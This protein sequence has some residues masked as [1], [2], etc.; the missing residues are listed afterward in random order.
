MINLGVGLLIILSSCQKDKIN[1]IDVNS[2][3]NEK[4][5]IISDV[6]FS[7]EKPDANITFRFDE[8]IDDLNG[9]AQP[10]FYGSFFD[11]ETKIGVGQLE[12]MEEQFFL[13]S[14][15]TYSLTKNI[16]AAEID[17]TSTQCSLFSESEKF[18]SFNKYVYMP[19]KMNVKSNIGLGEAFYKDKDLTL[20]WT[21]DINIEKV[22]IGVCS[23]GLP[24]III[25]VENSGSTTISKDEFS[26]FL[27]G[28]KVY[29]HLGRG[30]QNCIEMSNGN[31]ICFNSFNNAKTSG[32]IVEKM[33]K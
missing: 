27:I 26:D 20:N 18:D 3:I 24:C 7:K 4:S 31:E 30:V 5:L 10:T 8:Y 16:I 6:V 13:K 33:T 17:G 29:V 1:K 14:D 15:N 22:Y 9:L 25:E 28:N 23:V 21:P 19:K 2:I 11:N 32:H 12:V